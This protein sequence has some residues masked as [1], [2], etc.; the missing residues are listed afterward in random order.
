ME[1]KQQ[2]IDR[3]CGNCVFFKFENTDGNGICV[4]AKNYLKD[5]ELAYPLCSDEAC[6]DF[7]SKEE[8]LEHFKTLLC[9]K[10][11]QDKKC[12][13]TLLSHKAIQALSF[14]INHIKTFNK[15]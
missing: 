11:L 8:Q 2:P 5:T 9:M 6:N 3:H 12:G 7:I 14:V 15:L 13:T 4:C 1:T 10:G